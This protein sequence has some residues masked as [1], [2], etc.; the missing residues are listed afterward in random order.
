MTVQEFSNEF[1]ILFNNV[2]SNQA[3]GLDEY[4][5]SVFL[6]SAQEEIILNLYNGKNQ[7]EDSFEKTEELR[8]SLSDLM[9][10]SVYT[11]DVKESDNNKLSSKST[12]YV[13][14]DDLWFITYESIVDLNNNIIEVIPTTQDEYHRRRKNPF[15]GV[16][17]RRALRLE[18]GSNK[19]EIICNSMIK[20]YTIKYLRKPTPII[21]CSL[22]GGDLTINSLNA[23]TP[24]TLDTSLHRLILERAVQKAALSWS[25]SK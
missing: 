15:R 17:K 22:E 5:K 12:F 14:P 1:D 21:L 6:T 23:E 25:N 4:E 11:T 9:V 19:V 24:C 7:F 3:P 20:T 13:L 8:R 16:T 2:T 18:Y 10:T